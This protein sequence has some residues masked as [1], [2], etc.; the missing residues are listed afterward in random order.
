MHLDQK[1]YILNC[2][3]DIYDQQAMDYADIA[4]SAGCATCCTR[5]VAITTLEGF[6]ILQYI[7]ETGCRDRVVSLR[8]HLASARFVPTV[9]TNRFA[10]LCLGNEAVPED[11]M[12][13]DWGVCPL[14]A[15]G[16]C[17]IYPARPFACR[18]M[19]SRVRCDTSGYASMAD[20][21]VTVNTVFLQVIEQLDAGGHYGNLIDILLYIYDNIAPAKAAADTLVAT[22]PIPAL[23]IPPEHR[24]KIKPVLSAIQK[25]QIHD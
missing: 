4:C 3:Y 22:E 17:T 9:T 6:R 20:Y 23:M 8:D 13:T 16:L 12:D 5:N 25:I 19:L 15:D 1:L 11:A 7:E 2:L 24:E 10:A 18:C 21:A 14:L